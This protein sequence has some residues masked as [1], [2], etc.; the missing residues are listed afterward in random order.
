MHDLQKEKPH[1]GNLQM[2]RK[3]ME[4][5]IMSRMFSGRTGSISRIAHR[6]DYLARRRNE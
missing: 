5:T 2:P 1:D 3:S 6:R 4:E